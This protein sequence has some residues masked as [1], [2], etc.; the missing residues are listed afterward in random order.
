MLITGILPS[1][2]MRRRERTGR[3]EG[4]ERSYEFPSGKAKTARWDAETSLLIS[5]PVEMAK[6]YDSARDVG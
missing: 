2:T 1:L 4:E 6:L 5:R 3:R